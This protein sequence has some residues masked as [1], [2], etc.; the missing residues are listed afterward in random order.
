MCDIVD[1]HGLDDCNSV[2]AVILN[3]PKP[4]LLPLSPPPKS[5]LLR[6]V[7]MWKAVPKNGFLMF[8][9]FPLISIYLWPRIPLWG[10][11]L[12][13]IADTFVFLFLDKYGK[14]SG[15]GGISQRSCFPC[16]GWWGG[17]PPVISRLHFSPSGLRK[18]EAFFGFL[19]TVMAL[20]FGY[21]ASVTG[22]SLALWQKFFFAFYYKRC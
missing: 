2:S 6:L 10:G 9:L 11:V 15:N 16:C 5:L 4:D 3:Y 7:C 19:I 21:E 17:L 14:E 22:Y 12:I 18:L 13:T 8:H 20:T 1:S